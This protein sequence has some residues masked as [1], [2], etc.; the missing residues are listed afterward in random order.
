M[1]GKGPNDPQTIIAQLHEMGR[2]ESELNSELQQIR[3][4]R[5][6]LLGK[7]QMWHDMHAAKA[8]K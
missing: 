2:R 4:A 6:V 3:S 5:I 7:L 8:G 1:A